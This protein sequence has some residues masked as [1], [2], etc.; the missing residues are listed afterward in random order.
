MES[1]F[2]CLST[3]HPLRFCWGL[4]CGHRWGRLDCSV[5][6]ALGQCPPCDFLC[7]SCGWAWRLEPVVLG[8]GPEWPSTYLRPQELLQGCRSELVSVEARPPQWP[9]AL[10]TS[11]S[12]IGHSSHPLHFLAAFPQ[13]GLGNIWYG[14]CE[15]W[16]WWLVSILFY[17]F[18]IHF[19]I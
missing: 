4:S 7:G 3:I 2:I 9:V 11:P 13:L 16:R 5:L 1:D 10:S 15:S 18:Q 6:P 12:R 17:C 14:V 19:L 8:L